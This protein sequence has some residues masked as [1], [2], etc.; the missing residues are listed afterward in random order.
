MTSRSPRSAR[1]SDRSSHRI[2]RA[3]RLTG[4]DCILE[5]ASRAVL[6]R[7]GASFR[8]QLVENDAQRVDVGGGRDRLAGDLLG[9]RVV[10]RKRAPGHFRQRRIVARR[11]RRSAWRCR[12]RAAAPGPRTSRGCCAGFRSRCTISLA[13]AC[14]TALATC[15][16]R[17]RRCRTSSRRSRQYSLIGMPFDVLEREIRL[18]VCGDAGVVETRDVRMVE[19]R[20]ESPARAPCA[21]RGPRAATR[22][23]AASARSAD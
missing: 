18:A 16:N 5:R 19:R 1:R 7:I 3:D 14:A 12:N 15:R 13:C 22:R 2:A 20:P 17:R 6:R 21:Q 23:A 11:P 10:R 8:E 9:R 4:E